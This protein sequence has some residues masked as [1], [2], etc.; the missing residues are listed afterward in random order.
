MAAR[1]N[2][3][4]VVTPTSGTRTP[5]KDNAMPASSAANTGIWIMR[6]NV[7]AT[8]RRSVAAS[9]APRSARKNT[10]GRVSTLSTITFMPSTTPASA[11]IT[12]SSTG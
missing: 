8:W 2:R 6:S 5:A 10:S 9:A 4:R 3:S 1:P 12:V 7:P 11:G